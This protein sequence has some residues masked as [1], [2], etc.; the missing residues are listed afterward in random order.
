VQS[1]DRGLGIAIGIAATVT[2]HAVAT[3]MSDSPDSK[4]K[5]GASRWTCEGAE[6]V[7]VATIDDGIVMVHVTVRDGQKRTWRLARTV[8]SAPE[9]LKPVGN[10]C[11][12]AVI[13]TGD[14]DGGSIRTVRLKPSGG[15]PGAAALSRSLRPNATS[16]TN[17]SGHAALRA[18]SGALTCRVAA[19]LEGA[20][21]FNV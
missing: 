18:R 16:E 13:E 8:Y 20:F 2:V 15:D 17:A 12:P 9:I 11:R 7:A 6:L 14:L 19:V 10:G 5:P 21:G 1:V 4:T 3:F